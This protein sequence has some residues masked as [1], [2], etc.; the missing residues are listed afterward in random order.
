[1]VEGEGLKEGVA[2]AKPEQKNVV[3]MLATEVTKFADA[4]YRIEE[5]DEAG[6]RR[7]RERR[8]SARSRRP[9]QCARRR[10]A[11]PAAAPLPAVRAYVAR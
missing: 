11:A 9:L 5:C 2:K 10:P 7:T 1:M 3:D 6:R 8:T 4:V